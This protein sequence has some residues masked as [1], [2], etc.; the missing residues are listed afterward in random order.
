[1]EAKLCQT[2]SGVFPALATPSIQV[3][4][5]SKGNPSPLVIPAG[6]PKERSGSAVAAASRCQRYDRVRKSGG[7]G[8]GEPVEMVAVVVW[9]TGSGMLRVIFLCT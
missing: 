5:L 8:T 1:M 9:V 6:A 7:R 2:V 3:A 4:D